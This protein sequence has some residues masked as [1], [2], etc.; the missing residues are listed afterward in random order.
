MRGVCVCVCGGGGEGL[1]C[2]LK[3]GGCGGVGWERG[4]RDTGVVPLLLCESRGEW[5]VLIPAFVGALPPRRPGGVVLP[6]RKKGAA[7]VPPGPPCPRPLPTA[8]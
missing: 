8:L 1:A 2:E 7:P 6:P 5:G 4:G 3:S